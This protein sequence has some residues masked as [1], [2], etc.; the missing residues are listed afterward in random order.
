MI[1]CKLDSKTNN[2]NYKLSSLPRFIS[3]MIINDQWLSEKVIFIKKGRVLK[4]KMIFYII[5][6]KT[7][8]YNTVVAPSVKENYHICR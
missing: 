4:K 3:I 6:I 5:I 1:V 2:E 8:T 7:F